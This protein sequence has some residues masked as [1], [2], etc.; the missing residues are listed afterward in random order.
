ML[1]LVAVS[2]ATWW[3]WEGGEGE[4]GTLAVEKARALGSPPPLP[5]VPAPLRPLG[6]APPP[7]Q[8]RTQWF[9]IAWGRSE[10]Q[11]HTRSFPFSLPTHLGIGVLLEARVEDRV[12]HL[13]RQLVGVAFIDRLRGEEE[14]VGVR[15]LWKGRGEGGRVSEGG[16]GV[17]KNRREGVVSKRVRRP[18][19][20]RPP[21]W[22][23]GTARPANGQ[24]RR[25]PASA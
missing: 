23:A 6:P 14:G 9:T 4:C 7:P 3:W 11:A 21:G 25:A 20:R 24:G 8:R 5:R 22:R 15:H 1:V 2:Q 18:S 12:G 13:V 19:T 17:R 16:A 10:A